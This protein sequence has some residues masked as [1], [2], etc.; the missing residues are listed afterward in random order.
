[1]HTNT[2]THIQKYTNSH[3]HMHRNIHTH[4]D[5]FLPLPFSFLLPLCDAVWGSWR[6]QR[7][8]E[9]LNYFS[10]CSTLQFCGQKW[11]TEKVPID[12]CS[13]SLLGKQHNVNGVKQLQRRRLQISEKKLCHVFFVLLIDHSQS[14]LQSQCLQLA[15]IGGCCWMVVVVLVLLVGVIVC[16]Y[17]HICDCT[18]ACMCV[19]TCVCMSMCMH[20]CVCVYICVCL[21]LHASLDMC[22]FL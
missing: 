12:Y 4:T 15:V 16:L 1:M 11:M 18:F 2:H 20:V 6:L 22:V 19:Y 9:N 3:R 10:L 7:S 14:C 5:T 17:V 8:V 13:Y 21:C